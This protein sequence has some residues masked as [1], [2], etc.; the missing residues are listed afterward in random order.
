MSQTDRDHT[1]G[2]FDAHKYPHLQPSHLTGS[3]PS[4][5]VKLVADKDKSE[6]WCVQCNNRVTV[7]SREYGH[8][9]DCAYSCFEGAEQ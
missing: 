4:T 7:G 3:K 6:A 5:G 8:A 2:E 9:R 1:L